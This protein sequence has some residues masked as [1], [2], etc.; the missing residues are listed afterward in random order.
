MKNLHLHS[1]GRGGNPQRR[2][3]F[4]CCRWRWPG[5]L[6]FDGHGPLCYLEALRMTPGSPVHSQGAGTVE[7]GPWGQGRTGAEPGSSPPGS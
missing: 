5:E 3:L 4:L 1:S 6:A 7:A 2:V